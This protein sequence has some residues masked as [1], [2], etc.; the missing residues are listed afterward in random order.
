[1]RP[2]RAEEGWFVLHLFCRVDRRRWRELDPKE[3]I[4]SRECFERVVE[5]FRKT[6]NCHL[7]TYSI[8]GHKADLALMIIDPELN[9]LDQTQKEVVAVF[10]ENT[11]QPVHSYTSMT[12]TSEYLTHEDDYD[13]VLREK[14]G[15]TP[16]SPE[17]HKKM[18]GFRERMKIYVNERLHPRIPEHK[19][20]CFYPMNKGRGETK[21]W[22]ALDFETRKRLMGGHAIMG[23]KYAGKVQQFVTGSAGLDAW[24]WGVTL[25]ADDPFYLKKIVYEMR[26][27]EV[28]A[29]YGQFGDFYVGIRLEPQ[30]LFDRL[31]L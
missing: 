18:E 3:R 15:L 25:F 6:A 31:K 16:E 9:H 10:P 30:E 11:L 28:S 21:N 19:V 14:E 24:E 20:M 8:W 23:R 7:H 29:V 22:Y 1:M 13:R 26:F 17:Y 2:I 27:D 4:Q 5:D 12:E